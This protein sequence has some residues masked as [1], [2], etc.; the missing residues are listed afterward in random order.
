MVDGRGCQR[1]R[2]L[3]LV[4]V[5][6]KRVAF[7]K[8]SNGEISET[9]FTTSSGAP[10]R[11][12]AKVKGSAAASAKKE[13]FV[14]VSLPGAGRD[15]DDD[16]DEEDDYGDKGRLCRLSGE[17][18][19]EDGEDD[20]DLGASDG[21]LLD[22]ESG[23]LL[24]GLAFDVAVSIGIMMLLLFTATGLMWGIHK[25]VSESTTTTATSGF[26]GAAMDGGAFMRQLLKASNRYNYNPAVHAR[27][28]AADHKQAQAGAAKNST[29]VPVLENRTHAS[30]TERH[31]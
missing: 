28:F 12:K 29:T 24:R 3:D 8:V 13:T 27:D 23:R 6:Q 22:R 4:T 11:V 19:G 2:S 1:P 5:T 7:R 16:D 14:Y 17:E 21:G 26:T 15:E 9:S 10:R 18:D 20:D 25:I 30:T 31:N